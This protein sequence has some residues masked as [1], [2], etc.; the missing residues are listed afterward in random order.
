MGY[1]KEKLDEI[2]L[3]LR[4][5]PTVEKKKIEHSKQ[6]AIKILSKEI[7]QL[8]KR[9]YKLDQISEILK[10]EGLNIATP[11]LKSYL[12]RAKP[13]AEKNSVKGIASVES[14]GAENKKK[15]VS[16]SNKNPA[17]KTA[18]SANTDSTT[19]ITQNEKPPSLTP[20]I[21]PEPDEKPSESNTSQGSFT[22]K[23]DTK[24]I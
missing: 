16:S 9:G 14:K 24:N 5:M 23:P 21:T 12:Q 10:G 18:A 6:D 7:A 13:T 4:N 17:D 3:K 2:A 8:Q 19:M 1:T 15:E 20:D 22:P 11:T